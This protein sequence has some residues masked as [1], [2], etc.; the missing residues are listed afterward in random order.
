MIPDAA[1]LPEVA[2]LMVELCEIPSPSY[3]EGDVAA[4]VRA[5]LAALGCVVTEDDAGDVLGAGCGNI[6]GR[7]PA[8]TA[9]TPI[10][11]CAHLDTVPVD[12]PIEVEIMADGRLTNRWSAI[13]GG[14]DKAAIAAMIVAV[15]EV[16]REDLPHAGI[17]LLMTPCEEVGLR[18]AA[19]FDVSALVGGV[20]FVYD[21]T[22]PIG[23]IIIAAPWHRRIT[24]TFIGRAAHAGMA[25]E[26]GR[27]A[28]AAAADAIS[29]MRLGRVDAETTA[30]IGMI[31]GGDAINVVPARCDLVGEARSRRPERVAEQI[32][33]MVDALTG[34]AAMAGCDL[35]CRV[36]NEYE[37]YQLQGGDVQVAMAERALRRIG[38]RPRHVL[39]GGGSD[40][41][42]LLG[43]GVASVNLCNAMT[44]V[45]T[46][47]ESIAVADLERMVALTRA[48]IAEA[49]GA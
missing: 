43:K 45:H 46:P 28:I 47:N 14:D 25:P 31:S 22:G 26:A 40:V 17:E 29:R 48:I 27:S 33:A 37:G 13:L 15:R 36:H 42:A 8:R 18:G 49:A 24:A 6:L 19:H 34:A 5:E 30:N 23:D 7:L 16:I 2:R 32:S 44:D 1:G 4:R 20:G 12:A 11:L 10:V 3:Q 39:G 21:H 35:E 9:G 41:N 38:I